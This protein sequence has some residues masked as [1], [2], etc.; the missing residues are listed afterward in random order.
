MVRPE[1]Q[2]EEAGIAPLDRAVEPSGLLMPAKVEVD[3]TGQRL[4]W[5]VEGNEWRVSRPGPTLLTRFV[6]LGREAATAAHVATF[7][8][9]F[10][11]LGLC[12]HGQPSGHPRREP[13]GWCGPLGVPG[14]AGWWQEPLEP[15]RSLAR[16][17]QALL[18]AAAALYTGARDQAEVAWAAVFREDPGSAPFAAAKK[19]GA[20]R[21]RW[22]LSWY[23]ERWLRLGRVGPGLVWDDEGEPRV[24]LLTSEAISP[25]AFT[26]DVGG[27]VARAYAGGAPPGPYPLFGSL[28][29]RL[30]F[31]L[32]QARGLAACDGCQE[33]TPT[34]R[35][36]ARG[37]RFFCPDCRERGRPIVAATRAYRQRRAEALRLQAEGL[38]VEAIA[39]RVGRPTATVRKWL[40]QQGH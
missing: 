19:R 23:V 3:P 20:I 11:V 2:W 16:Q 18:N 32:G 40:L 12:R 37:R 35:R 9:E 28:A 31:A 6:Q 36:P 30:L 38:G 7:A 8:R 24:L 4:L 17:A 14:R 27:P 1:R 10:G 21:E 33:F 22:L 39:E 15:W 5:T 26:E 13:A 29:A 25:W 34:D